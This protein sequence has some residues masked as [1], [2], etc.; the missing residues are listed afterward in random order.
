MACGT[1]FYSRDCGVINQND[2][3]RQAHRSQLPCSSSQIGMAG[4]E[5]AVAD[6]AATRRAR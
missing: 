2:L 5:R 6:R 4:K 1:A 3:R